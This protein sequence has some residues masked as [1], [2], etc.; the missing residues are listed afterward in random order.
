MNGIPEGYEF[1]RVGRAMAGETIIATSG[2]PLVLMKD[3]VS[4]NCVVV[5][6]MKPNC[7]FPRGVFKDGWIT[8]DSTN[9]TF[10]WSRKPE[11]SPEIK[12]FT[13]NFFVVEIGKAKDSFLTP[14]WFHPLMPKEKCIQ[15]V[16]PNYESENP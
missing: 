4:L 9:G 15:Q 11:W 10:W 1:V 13:G 2:Q 3:S 8:H 7:E 14:V 12:Q 6:K 5:R 16:G